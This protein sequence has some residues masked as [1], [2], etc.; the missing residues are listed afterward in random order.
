MSAAMKAPSPT[1][2]APARPEPQPASRT[3]VLLV[4]LG[5]PEATDPG[6]VRR[7]LREFLSDRRVIEASPLIWRP[8]L[9][10]V[11]LPFR[12][13]RSGAAYARIWDKER[14]ESPLKT[15]T[16]GQAEKLAAALADAGVVVDWAMR[17][18]KPAIRERV[19]AM[20]EQGC[21]RILV[22]PL[23]PQYSAT[24][25]ASVMDAVFATLKP[26]RE[27]PTL[28]EMPPYYGDPDYIDA[29]AVSI[30]TGLDRLPFEPQLVLASYHGLPEAYVARG[31]PYRRH[32]EA[33]TELLRQRLGWREDYLPMS[34]QSRFGRAEWLKPYTAGLIEQFAKAG[35]KRMAVVTPG[36][37]A[38][39][40]ETLEEIG[41]ENAEVFRHHGGAEYAALPCLNDSKEGMTMLESLVRRELQ[42][43]V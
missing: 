2:A 4:N 8:I 20:I 29:L 18:G 9:E 16:R 1:G 41:I 24:T 32:C 14:N 13:R 33:T 28:R 35:V 26:M 17:Y 12:S 42:G 37:S 40:I 7:Y 31:D 30:I 21:D 39:C 5:T 43:W 27:Q 23:Y 22:A 36:F 38:D 25:T 10:C 11:V 15:I 6:S 34:F 19:D 3:G